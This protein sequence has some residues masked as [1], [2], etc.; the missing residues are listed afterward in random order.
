VSIVVH[1]DNSVASQEVFYKNGR[2][3]VK[4]TLEKLL[5]IFETNV[6]GYSSNLQRGLSPG[7]VVEG[8]QFFFS[9]PIDD[10]NTT[11]STVRQKFDESASLF[12][13]TSCQIEAESKDDHRAIIEQLRRNARDFVFL[14]E[15]LVFQKLKGCLH[16]DGVDYRADSAFRT[17]MIADFFYR[18]GRYGL[19]YYSSGNTFPGF[20]AVFRSADES[21]MLYPRDWGNKKIE[22]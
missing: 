11:S 8:F 5:A 3:R 13:V 7:V 14:N 15:E 18:A 4:V 22:K 1:Q 10:G 9:F 17:F 21:M 16:A 6:R 2:I 12:S 20:P 19:G